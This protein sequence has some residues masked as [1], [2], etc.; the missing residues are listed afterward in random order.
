M[1]ALENVT[2]DLEGLGPLNW[3]AKKVI[4][5]IVPQNI[6]NLLLSTG[7]EIFRQIQIF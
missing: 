4:L 2:V 7:R 1:Q 5:G 6:T 3:V